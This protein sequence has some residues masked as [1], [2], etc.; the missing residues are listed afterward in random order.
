MRLAATKSRLA[1]QPAV[2]LVCG[3][4]REAE[5]GHRFVTSAF[6]R[7]VAIVTA[8]IAVNQL[9]PVLGEA[10]EGVDLRRIDDI[11]E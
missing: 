7:G 3:E 10:F 8:V 6:M 4:A 2:L 5:K 9:H 11:L 1:E